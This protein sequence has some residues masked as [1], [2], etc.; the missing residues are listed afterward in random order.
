MHSLIIL[1][2]L[3]KFLSADLVAPP[4]PPDEDNAVIAAAAS[5]GENLDNTIT[6]SDVTNEIILY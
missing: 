4:P 5:N 3:V 6:I 2:A 1:T